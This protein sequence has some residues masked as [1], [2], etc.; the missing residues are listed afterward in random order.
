[1]FLDTA[2]DANQMTLTDTYGEAFAQ[3]IAFAQSNDADSVGVLLL[4]TT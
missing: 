2:T 1:M 3:A 4:T